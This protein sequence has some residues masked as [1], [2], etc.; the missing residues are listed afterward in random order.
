MM[1]SEALSR[2]SFRRAGNSAVGTYDADLDTC[3]RGLSNQLFFQLRESSLKKSTETNACVNIV[4]SI[5]KSYTV[6]PCRREY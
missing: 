1:P 5:S 4:V 6:Y 3:G 2:V